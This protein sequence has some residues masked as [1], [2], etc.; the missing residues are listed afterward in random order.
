MLSVS[1]TVCSALTACGAGEAKQPALSR[2]DAA[3]LT[4]LANRI[5]GE[6]ACAQ[7][8]DIDVLRR[9]VIV[10]VDARR[11]PPRLS[12][13]LMRGVDSLV[14][15]SPLCVSAVPPTAPPPPKKH[16]HG[17]QH[18]HGHGHGDKGKGKGVGD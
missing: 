5:A 6:G 16:D 14:A 3:Q 15:D 13:A 12:G 9:R 8:R 2:G 7:R 17:D 18:H 10:L 1:L 11:V 4:A